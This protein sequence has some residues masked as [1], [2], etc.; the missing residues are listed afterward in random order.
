MKRVLVLT[1]QAIE[2]NTSSMIRVLNII[3]EISA[4]GYEVDCVVAHPNRTLKYY[5]EDNVIDKNI[6]VYRFGP[7]KS[8]IMKIDNKKR[9]SLKYNILTMLRKVYKLFDLFDSSIELVK[10]TNQIDDIVKNKKYDYFLSFSDPKT[11]HIISNNVLK[12]LSTRPYYIQQWG[13]P[14]ALDITNKSFVPKFIKKI[15]EYKLIKK[16]DKVIYV[17]PITLKKQKKLYPKMSDRMF[18]VPTP[19]LKIESEMSKKDS[20]NIKIG[21]FGSYNAVV[22][23]ILPLYHSVS[24]TDGFELKVI[25]DSDI[26]LDEK[27][28][29]IVQKRVSSEKIIEYTNECDILVCILNNRG[30]QIPGKIYHYAGSDKEILII[31]DG[32]YGKAIKGYF[33]K[34]GRYSF[35][36]NTESSIKNRLDRYKNE[37]IPNR[38]PL[39][40]FM[41]HSVVQDIMDRKTKL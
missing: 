3:N 32:E 10:Y 24:K 20:S 25:G 16:A 13:D 34:F 39:E 14:L 40:A 1:T 35:C 6:N 12:K 22:R 30:S 36:E 28:N 17:S 33:N 37:G 7:S 5:S 29:I 23:D 21:Y 41:P 38:K 26:E 11:S 2:Y 4:E 31:T 8:L 18:F 27:E 15:I 9:K 19:C